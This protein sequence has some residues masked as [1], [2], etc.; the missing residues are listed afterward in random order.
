M[1]TPP[2][3]MTQLKL[4]IIHSHE[5]DSRIQFDE[6]TH[7]YTV[8]NDSTSYQSVTTLIHS[9]C[10]PFDADAI[11]KKMMSGP[12]RDWETPEIS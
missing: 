9:Y 2:T 8:D 12:Y 7:V 4:D 1:P 10:K 3:L 5:R 6:P 11:I